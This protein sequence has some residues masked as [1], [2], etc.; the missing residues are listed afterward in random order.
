MTTEELIARRREL[1]A[2]ADQQNIDWKTRLSSLPQDD[3]GLIVA[4]LGT[5][6]GLNARRALDES[7]TLNELLRYSEERRTGEVNR[8]L[9]ERYANE[10]LRIAGIQAGPTS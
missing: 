2:M 5:I 10:L 6:L 1:Q 3:D 8:E 9:I 4:A 7:I